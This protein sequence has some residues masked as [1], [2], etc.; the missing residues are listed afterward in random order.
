MTKQEFEFLVRRVEDM[1]SGDPELGGVRA[2][3]DGIG[4]PQ[5]FSVQDALETIY[6]EPSV[7]VPR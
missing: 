4:A 5:G 3:L 6:K 1:Y 2:L 7:R